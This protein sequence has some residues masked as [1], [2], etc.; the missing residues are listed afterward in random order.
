MEKN[1]GKQGAGEILKRLTVAKNLKKSIVMFNVFKGIPISYPAAVLEVDERGASFEVHKYQAVALDSE[2]RTQLRASIFPKDI[3][4]KVSSVEIKKTLAA[5]S[6][7]AYT[8]A[9][10]AKREFVRIPPPIPPSRPFC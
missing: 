3:K 7:F 2:K 1:K 8:D 6:D 5:L 9:P 4:A 10:V